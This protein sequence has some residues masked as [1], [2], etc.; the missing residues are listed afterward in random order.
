MGYEWIPVQ[1]CLV[2]CSDRGMKAAEAQLY[3]KLGQ[4]LKAIEIYLK[5]DKVE[6]A[7]QIALKAQQGWSVILEHYRGD[8]ERLIYILRQNLLLSVRSVADQLDLA[9][10]V[11]K[12]LVKAR[13]YQLTSESKLTLYQSGV[14]ELDNFCVLLSLNEVDL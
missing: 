12:A 4:P 7:C 9:L 14:L 13:V 5:L 11:V 6:S 2:I 3:Q 1:K 10:G 8:T